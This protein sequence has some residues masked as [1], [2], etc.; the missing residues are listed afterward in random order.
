V[1]RPSPYDRVSPL[2]LVVLAGALGLSILA[3]CNDVTRFSTEAGESYCG[4]IV[5]GPFVRQGFKPDV[6]MRM[7]FDADRIDT[8]PGVLSTS[9]GMFTEAPLRSIPQLGNDPLSTLQF[10]EGRSRNLF[11]GVSP[12]D[13]QTAFAVV[14]LMENGNVE[15]RVVRGAPPPAGVTSIPAHE[16]PTLF[17]VFPLTRQRSRCDF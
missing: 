10:G 7:S 13:G 11:V 14:S 8:Q 4:N 9:D 3:G 15:V 16:A 2:A 1:S 12:S 17:G 5:P 6:R